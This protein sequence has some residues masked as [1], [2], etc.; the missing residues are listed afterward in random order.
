M[1]L[2]GMLIVDPPEGPGFARANVPGWP[3]FDPAKYLVPYDVEAIWVPDEMDS[4][5]H[6][7]G[8]D[9][10]MMD[11]DEDDPLNAENFTKDGILNDF[12]PDVFLVSGVV[13]DGTPI[14]DPRVKITA[15]AGQT[16]LIRLLCAGYAIQEYNFGID[17]TII[18]MDGR[19]LGIPPRGLYSS[20]IALP[21]GT[22]FRLTSARRVDLLIR[23]PAPGI[24][25]VRFRYL[26]WIRGNIVH[27]ATTYIQAI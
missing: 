11:C 5:W 13:S 8:H 25:P 21:A 14:F 16:I 17:A 9:A 10:F 23:P 15:R 4:V 3:G 18:A 22:P 2:Y 24:W 7:L 26:D 12:R 6:E 19:S 20:P 27:T 1:G